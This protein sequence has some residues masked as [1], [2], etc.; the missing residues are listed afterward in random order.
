MDVENLL[1]A[2]L[3]PDSVVIRAAEVRLKEVTRTL[4]GC[5]LLL[6]VLNRVSSAPT[7]RQLA[8]T[9]LRRHL[10]RHWD[11]AAGG[12]KLAV[13]NGLLQLLVEEGEVGVQQSMVMLITAV[14][15]VET[16]SELPS[17]IAGLVAEGQAVHLRAIGFVLL[18]MLVEETTP[19]EQFP[20]RDITALT[21]RSIQDDADVAVRINAL[22]AFGMMAIRFPAQS[23]ESIPCPL[24]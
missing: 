2:A 18:R 22:R 20:V 6:Q 7:V 10:P 16:W 24:R 12:E 3:T 1:E 23:C 11:L 4:E 21:A 15:E 19:E 13:K 9:L 17:F 5:G 14:A 8:A